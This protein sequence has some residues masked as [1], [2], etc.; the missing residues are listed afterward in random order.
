MRS[1]YVTCG[2]IFSKVLLKVVLCTGDQCFS[3]LHAQHS[4]RLRC[5]RQGEVAQ[6]AK[7][8]DDTFVFLRGQQLQRLGHQHA[9]DVGVDLGEVGRFEGHGDAEFGQGVAELRPAFIQQSHRFRAFGLQPP[10]HFGMDF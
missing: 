4:A 2:P 8:V 9:V 1:F 5:Q 3:A 7:P 6:A 10:L